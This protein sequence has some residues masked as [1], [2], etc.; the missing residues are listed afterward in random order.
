MAKTI[1][2]PADLRDWKVTSFVGKTTAVKFT[3]YQERLI[4]ILLRM[5]FSDTHLSAKAIIPMNMPSISPKRLIFIESV[6][7]LDGISNYLDVYVQDN[8]TKKP[9][10]CTYLQKNSQVLKNL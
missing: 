5:R 9:V 1:K 7:E 2:L 6:K 10:I 8:Q 3:R 4:K